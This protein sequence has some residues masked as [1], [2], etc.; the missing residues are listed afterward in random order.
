MPSVEDVS[1]RM[2]FVGGL[3]RS[4]TSLL[5]RC[6]GD[7]PDVSVFSDTGVPEDE[8]Q[9]LQSV[10][11]TAMD[12][13]G[14]GR[15]GFDPTAHLTEDS[16]LAT[17]RHAQRLL[18]D[19]APYWDL[20]AKR[21][22]EKSPPNLIRARFLQRHFP[23]ARF[24]FLLRHPVATSYATQKWSRTPLR[25]LIEHW[26]VC[27]ERFRQDVDHIERSLVL[28]YEDV[29]RDPDREI[30]RVFTFLGLD[31][32]PVAQEVRTGINDAYFSRFERSGVMPAA[33]RLYIQRRFERRVQ[34]FGYSLRP[35][36]Y[37]AEVADPLGASV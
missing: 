9:H 25:D 37:V 19:W 8:G 26:L 3:H 12:H 16:P 22:I 4:G 17:D 10:Y 29:V 34:I 14:A 6:L 30:E 27:H 35:G 21:L 33:H 1:H 11:P 31:P 5:H 18:D 20:S 13:G 23:G 2:V 28:R 32:V 24:V 15:F 36:R 7:H